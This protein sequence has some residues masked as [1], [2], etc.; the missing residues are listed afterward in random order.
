VKESSVQ[1]TDDAAITVDRFLIEMW[2]SAVKGTIRPTTFSSYEMRVRCYLV[3]AFGRLELE[4]VT[5]PAINGFYGQLQQG[6]NGRGVLSAS[7]VRRIHAT[8]HRA[9]R[10]ALRWQLLLRNPAGAADP[11]RASPARH[12]G[13]DTVSASPV[14]A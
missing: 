8:L 12:Q 14:S 2:L 6:W 9:L 5:P 10:D 13:L 4:A 1:V 11:P 3:P 7:T